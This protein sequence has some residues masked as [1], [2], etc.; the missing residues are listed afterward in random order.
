MSSLF[1]RSLDTIAD[2]RFLAQ[3]DKQFQQAIPQAQIRALIVRALGTD[4]VVE[5]DKKETE[6]AEDQQPSAAPRPPK[7]KQGV[8]KLPPGVQFHYFASHKKQHSRFG[9]DSASGSSQIYSHHNQFVHA[10]VAG[11]QI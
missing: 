9:R 10:G 6:N 1:I 3:D 11:T 7:A 8:S 5:P 4:T 2:L